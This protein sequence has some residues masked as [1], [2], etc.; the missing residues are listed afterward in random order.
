MLHLLEKST[1]DKRA[2]KPPKLSPMF[3]IAV[4]SRLTGRQRENLNSDLHKRD[5]RIFSSNHKVFHIEYEWDEVALYKFRFEELKNR[6][7]ANSFGMKW[8][9]M[10][11]TVSFA[12]MSG[13]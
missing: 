10:K 9:S 2:T 13:P 8:S 5:I 6:S 1:P 7:A 12:Q 3:V 4:T 11:V